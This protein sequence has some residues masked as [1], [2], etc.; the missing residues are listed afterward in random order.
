MLGSLLIKLKAT[1][2]IKKRLQHRSIPVK[3]AEFSRTPIFKS[4]CEQLLLIFRTQHILFLLCLAN[5]IHLSTISTEYKVGIFFKC[6]NCIQSNPIISIMY[7]FKNVSI[8]ILIKFLLNIFKLLK[9]Y[10][11]PGKLG[12]YNIAPKSSSIEQKFCLV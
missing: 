3:L 11:T 9:F 12:C 4:I 6:N 7:K 10:F 8:N 5:F 2:F 1:N